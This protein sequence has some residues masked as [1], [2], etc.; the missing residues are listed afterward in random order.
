MRTDAAARSRITR[1]RITLK[2]KSSIN[3]YTVGVRLSLFVPKIVVEATQAEV[4]SYA[5][6]VSFGF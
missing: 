2:D 3:R 4:R 6:K 5:A 1:R